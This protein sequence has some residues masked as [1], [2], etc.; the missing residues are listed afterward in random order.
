MPR[1]H[2]YLKGLAETRAR[3]D[4][5]CLRAEKRLTEVT[6][7]L[8]RTR[9]QLEAK[10]ARLE[11]GT[12]YWARVAHCSRAEREACDLLI[13]KYDA[14]LVPAAIVPINGWQGRYGEHGELSKLVRRFVEMAYPNA[15]TT[16]EVG[17]WLQAQFSLVF[18][19]PKERYI[20]VRNT[21]SNMLNYLV[22]KGVIER[23]H[24]LIVTPGQPGRWRWIPPAGSSLDLAALA[25]QAGTTTTYAADL[26]EVTDLGNFAK[27]ATLEDEDGLPR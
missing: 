17:Q 5:R 12:L 16:T 10:C 24:D 25:A 23:C 22:R 7:L 26:A 8:V 13:K 18:S 6:Q 19:T 9:A 4:D 21:V 1:T 14:L 20:W 27:E 3:A 11:K 15:I 2:P